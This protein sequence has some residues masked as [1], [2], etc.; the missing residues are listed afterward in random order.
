MEF[1]F[2]MGLWGAALL[3]IASVVFGVVIYVYGNPRFGLEWLITSIAAFVGAFVAS[4]FIV[5]LRTWE[6]VLDGL[7]LVPALVGGVVIGGI[8]AIA[9]RLTSAQPTAHQGY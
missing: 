5:G 7:A 6:P 9:A 8:V 2:S 1:T 4:E 3:A